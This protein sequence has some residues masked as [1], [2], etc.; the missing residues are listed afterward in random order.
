MKKLLGIVLSCAMVFSMAACGAT[1]TTT[2]STAASTE[3]AGEAAAEGGNAS[4]LKIGVILVGDETEGYSAA[5]I[6]GIKTAAAQNMVVDFYIT[7]SPTSIC[8][9]MRCG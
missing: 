2:T 5:H 7:A 9:R 6:E 4:D 3:S 8:R 1:A